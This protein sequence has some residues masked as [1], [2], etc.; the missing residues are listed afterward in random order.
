MTPP[1]TPIKHLLKHLFT[2]PFNLLFKHLLRRCFVSANDVSPE[3]QT[4]FDGGNGEHQGKQKFYIWENTADK[5]KQGFPADTF[6]GLSEQIRSLAH[7]ML[8]GSG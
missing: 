4:S 1:K 5:L 3:T 2:C 8:G 7:W 6:P